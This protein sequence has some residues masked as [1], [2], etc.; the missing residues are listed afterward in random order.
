MGN[1]GNQMECN[2]RAFLIIII[3]IYSIASQMSNIQEEFQFDSGLYQQ[4]SKS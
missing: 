3:F 2:W 1:H 4:Y